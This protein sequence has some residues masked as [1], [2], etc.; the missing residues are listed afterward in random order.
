MTT[1]KDERSTH[2]AEPD[3]AVYD[4]LDSLLKEAEGR[5]QE[6]AKPQA[7][8]AAEVVEIRPVETLREQQEI[9]EPAEAAVVEVAEDVAQE[10]AVVV[11]EWAEGPF[12][13]LLFTLRGMT[14]AVPLLS[15]NSIMKWE[16]EVTPIPGQPDWHMGVILHRDQ[17]VVVID[18]AQLLV[19]ER[20]GRVDE[21]RERGSHILVIGEGDRG[22]ACESLAKP[23][24]LTKDDIRWSGA[25]G[26][27]PWV[28]G[29]IVEKLC[30]L[31]NVDYL[32]EMVRH[33]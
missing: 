22:L 14:L 5:Q 33:E 7:G 18:T 17:Q 21:V 30:I 26:N 9:L 15:L 6:P 3:Q 32:L 31:L 24:T 25:G 29:T 2:L 4:Y 16:E 13:C 23:L 10:D 20:L 12:Q 27:R 28:A 8:V 19:P 1:K 11:P